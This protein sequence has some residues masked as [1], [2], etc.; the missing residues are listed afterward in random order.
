[1]GVRNYTYY[2]L[3]RSLCTSCLNLID[4]K[5]V[6][7]N[8]NVYLL[9]HCPTHGKEKVLVA[10]D[11]AARGIDVP[12]VGLVVNY[13]VPNQDM[14]Y[15]HRIGR[16]A[17]AGAKGNAITLVS[18][19]SVGDWNIIKKQIKTEM[20]DLN[21]KLGVEIN[22]PDPLKRQVGRRIAPQIRSGYGRRD[23]RVR[24]FSSG[25]RR[26]GGH[27]R[28]APARDQY[29]KKKFARSSYSKSSSRKRW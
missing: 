21:Q 19:S 24:N 12:K 11:V 14:V 20:T 8:D 28:D 1:M 4:A 25:G 5:V 7:Q 22:I 27:K 3:T 10:T 17:R 26:S 9:K 23:T 2:D 15:F 18:Y 6:F 16:T 13:D 29:K